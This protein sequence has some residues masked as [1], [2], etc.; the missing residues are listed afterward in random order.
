VLAWGLHWGEAVKRHFIAVTGVLALLLAGCSGLTSLGSGNPPPPPPGQL[1]VTP[2]SAT[3]RGGDTQTFTAKLNGSAVAANWSVNGVAGG[4][5]TTG[6]I[7]AAGLYTAPEFPPSPNS[8]TI[9]AVESADATKNA[10]GSV[11]LNNPIPQITAATPMTIQ[12]GAFSLTVNGAHF[13]NSAAIY[14]GSTAL[15]T[16]R[17]SSTQLTATGTA[18][19][20][21]VGAIS[22]TVKNPDPGAISSAGLSAQ[23]VN[24]T[25]IN[26][27]VS[28]ATAT[29]LAGGQQSFSA[30]VT[31]STDQNVTWSVNGA[32]GGAT[33][34]G[35]I[36]AQGMYTAP[37]VLPSPN[38]I[39]ISAASVVDATKQGTGAVT[40]QN[41]VP[42]LTGLD[43]S[44]MGVG[45]FVIT[46]MGS[47]FGGGATVTFGGQALK[48]AFVSQTQLTATGTVAQAGNV[49]VTVT[50]PS[51]GGGTSGVLMAQIV[52]NG[53]VVSAAAAVR[54]LEQSSFGPSA[55][56]VNQLQQTGFDALLQSQFA[57]PASAY[58]VPT[59][60]DMG[61]GKVQQQFFLNAIYGP[62]QL[63]QRLAFS[64]N[65]IWV[66]GAN[67]V[68]DPTGYSNYVGALT[69]D[70]LG[71]YYSVMKDVT[72]TPAMGHWL[73]MVNNDKPGTGQHAN[74]NYARELMQLFTLGLNQL[75]S[76]GTAVLDGTGNPI[77]TYT[78]DDVMT[79]GRAL[80]GWT[81]PT[82]P[83]QTLQ[84]HNPEYYGGPMLPLESNHDAGAKTLLGQSVAAGQSAGQELDNVLTIIFNHP[85]LPPFVCKQFIE[86]L[87]T[88]NPSPAYVQ[89]VAQAFAN[90]KF[91][92]YGSG[93]RG[94]MQATVAAI[95]LDA[96]ARRGDSPATTV[97]GDG[98]L[99]EPIVMIVSIARAFHAATDGSGFESR[100]ASMSEDIFNSGSVFN[101][102]PPDSLIP[103][104]TLNGPEFAIF[105]TNTSLARVNL[106][107][108]AAYGGFNSSAKLDFSGVITAGTP[109]QMLAWLNNLF[110]HGTMSD[111]MKQSMLTAIAA[112]ST[113]NPPSTSDLTNQAKAAIYLVTSSSQYQV[114]R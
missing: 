77:P 62:D 15:S 42:V 111:A 82:Q 43:P 54:F 32:A 109:D 104:T 113:A 93:K 69:N 108:S 97:P 21:Q 76:D 107:N 112:I 85:N 30:T 34:T 8:I 99:R 14:F 51:P 103:Q 31:G 37:A 106:I 74:E 20:G 9:G 53:T 96:E 5:A 102:F 29:M 41:A 101:F 10:N 88:S 114:Q 61:L 11:T 55:E 67:K 75:N 90:G 47:G 25:G 73:D 78:Q 4:S 38:T 17:V 105:N 45:G 80:T 12:V 60:S 18:T 50:N 70:G 23:I 27:Q 44:P 79:L 95:L 110:L 19:A 3:L 91:N 40:L 22:I 28:P 49:P 72:L 26:V 1:V 2:A 86:K 83:G 87:V 84:K 63:R 58:P 59:A 71:N 100:G 36:T 66:V 33:A 68:S 98:K 6:T 7:S 89:R 35:T 94:D 46:V 64:L 57:E 65:E 16:T 48:T 39:T 52:N 13:A 56:Q 92:T 81:Y 24:N